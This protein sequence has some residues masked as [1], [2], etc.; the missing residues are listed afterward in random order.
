M[1]N[2]VLPEE[3]LFGYIFVTESVDLSSFKFSW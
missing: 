3:K 1:P 2:F